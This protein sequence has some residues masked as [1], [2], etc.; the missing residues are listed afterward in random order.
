ME[1]DKNKMI[2]VRN[3][4]DHYC[5]FEAKTSREKRDYVF[6]PAQVV[7]IPSEEIIFQWTDYNRL[8]CGFGGEQKPGYHAALYIEDADL[9]KQLG[10]ETDT[11]EQ[12]ILDL[13]K[14]VSYFQRAP[15][16]LD[17]KLDMA[18]KFVTTY[19]KR[20]LQ[21]AIDEGHITEHKTVVAAQEYLSKAALY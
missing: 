16:V 6:K 7:P 1:F 5:G 20:L 15:R 18:N 12:E 3:T 19:D 10:L 11:Y 8:F 4:T 14:V 2:G 17:L 9:R 21:K 13:N